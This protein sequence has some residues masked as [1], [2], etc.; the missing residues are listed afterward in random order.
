V[1]A[2]KWTTPARLA[3]RDNGYEPVLLNGK[4]PLLKQ[5]STLSATAE[6]VAAWQT[7]YPGAINT[8]ILT[9]HVPAVDIDVLD[10]EVGDIIHAWVRE[11]IPSGTPE[12]IR[13]GQSPKRA[14]LFR[15]DKPFTKISTGKWVDGKEIEHQVEVLCLGQQIVVYGNHPN[16]GRAY[17]WIGARPGQTPRTSLPLLTPEA[18]QTLIDRAR[19][20]FQ[21]RGWQPKVRVT[22]PP[23]PESSTS[24][25]CA[26]QFHAA[27]CDEAR[28][29]DALSYINADDYWV[30]LYVGMALEHQ[31]GERGRGL[32]EQWASQS[33]KYN[34]PHFDYTWK[35]LGKRAGITI[36]TLFYYAR[37]GGWA[38]S[39][40]EL[41]REAWRAAGRCI[42]REKMA[43]AL[44]T[45]FQWADHK[46]LERHAALRIFETIVDKELSK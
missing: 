29:V 33:K 13:V 21:E 14:I 30:W 35:A 25:R 5:W 24:A 39:P 41:Q 46:G 12:L 42:R 37:R 20:L 16:T 45:F 28:V 11:L 1:W 3:L 22:E 7:S 26:L 43:T 18:A 17:V 9:R 2:P 36:G 6:D 44:R 19:T 40:T 23:R 4:I 31:F 34:F 10:Q 15:C 38:P 32:W 8:G 27:D